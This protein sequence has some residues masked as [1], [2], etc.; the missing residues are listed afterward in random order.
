M[1]RYVKYPAYLFAISLVLLL[2][3]SLVHPYSMQSARIEVSHQFSAPL[4]KVFAD[5]EDHVEFG[6]ILGVSI[7]RIAS[8]E[9]GKNGLHSVR[10]I[11]ESF[12]GDFEE[13]IVDY[14][15]EKRIIYRVTQGGLV[16][17]H[18][19]RLLFSRIGG[20]TQ[21]DYVISFDSKLRVP[22][23]SHLMGTVLN[24]AIVDGFERKNEEYKETFIK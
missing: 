14:E 21:V 8:G 23:L 12:G 19:G 24:V 5:F 3:V 20:A 18:E 13:T 11:S 17:N 16:K 6:R 22:Y 9:D 1:P 2:V 7:E 10:K 4:S 15:R